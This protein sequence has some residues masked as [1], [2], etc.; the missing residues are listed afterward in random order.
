[1][2]LLDALALELQ[3]VIRCHV[4]LGSKPQSLARVANAISPPLPA[5]R[6]CFNCVLVFS[7]FCEK[8]CQEC[9][10][11]VFTGLTALVHHY[12]ETKAEKNVEYL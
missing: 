10:G 8:I 4:V 5:P 2:R 7:C 6:V 12:G 11:D 3:T 1:M 9:K